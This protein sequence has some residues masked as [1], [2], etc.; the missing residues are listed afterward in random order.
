MAASIAIA[1]GNSA[2]PLDKSGAAAETEH[3]H[4]WTVFV[5]SGDGRVR[6]RPRPRSHPLLGITLLP[7]SPTGMGPLT[8]PP[9]PRRPRCRTCGR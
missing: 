5:K 2:T 3:T 1:Y 9:P 8:E 6:K 4:S 7:L